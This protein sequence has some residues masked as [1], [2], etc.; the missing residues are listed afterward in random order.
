M[1]EKAWCEEES[2]VESGKKI[3]ELKNA[4]FVVLG[5]KYPFPNCLTLNWENNQWNIGSW[6]IQVLIAWMK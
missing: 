3:S 5:E 6:N 2:S 4:E 1:V